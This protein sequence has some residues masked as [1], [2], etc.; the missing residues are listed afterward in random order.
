MATLPYPPLLTGHLHQSSA[1]SAYGLIHFPF[2]TA[3]M[4]PTTSSL[5][6]PEL[7]PPEVIPDNPIPRCWALE[8]CE[9]EAECCDDVGYVGV[10]APGCVY[11]R[12]ASDDELAGE[13]LVEC[14]DS[15]PVVSLLCGATVLEVEV[16]VVG[17]E[18]EV[19]V[20]VFRLPVLLLPPWYAWY[21]LWVCGGS[22]GL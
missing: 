9:C 21:W 4:P 20:A 16:E 18:V 7:P 11:F 19:E 22:A 10:S 2:P 14:C 8:E 1:Y 17:V 12:D 3:P 6:R 13:Y 5:S 15:A